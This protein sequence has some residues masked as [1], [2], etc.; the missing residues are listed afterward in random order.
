M[1]YSDVCSVGIG[2][3]L[4]RSWKLQLKVDKR[5]SDIVNMFNAKIQGWINYYGHFYK[6]ELVQALRYVNQYLIK[7]VRRKYKKR[8]HRR[9]AE[10]WLGRVEL[11]DRN[12]FAHW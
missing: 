2:F 8:K 4:N 11:C 6:S 1:D 10:Y 12:L 7:W 3:H 5:L 9:R